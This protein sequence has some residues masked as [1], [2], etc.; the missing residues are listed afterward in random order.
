MTYYT[1]PQ[2]GD[3][4]EESDFNSIKHQCGYFV[5]SQFDSEARCY[6]GL[7]ADKSYFKWSE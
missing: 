2:S 4:L 7:L 6:G 1:N 3:T 5:E